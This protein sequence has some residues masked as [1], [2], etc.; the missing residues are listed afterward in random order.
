MNADHTLY[1]RNALVTAIKK[2]FNINHFPVESDFK[3]WLKAIKLHCF[4]TE[5]A[6]PVAIIVSS[7]LNQLVCLP[8]SDTLSD[9]NI[10]LFCEFLRKANYPLVIYWPKKIIAQNNF[11][12]VRIILHRTNKG[13]YSNVHSLERGN[14]A[15]NALASSIIRKLENKLPEYHFIES[16]NE[17]PTVSLAQG[18]TLEWTALQLAYDV[19]SHTESYHFSSARWLVEYQKK[20]KTLSLFRDFLDPISSINPHFFYLEHGLNI[21]Q[22]PALNKY[23]RLP[24]PS[25][26]FNISSRTLL[27]TGVV[28]WM[29]SQ[30]DVRLKYLPI[31]YGFHIIRKKIDARFSNP[32]YKL[33]LNSLCEIL[34]HTTITSLDIYSIASTASVL[35]EIVITRYIVM[36]CE[37]ILKEIIQLCVKIPGIILLNLTLQNLWIENND[38]ANQTGLSSLFLLCIQFIFFVLDNY[39]PKLSRW[40]INQVIEE[41][42]LLQLNHQAIQGNNKLHIVSSV[43]DRSVNQALYPTQSTLLEATSGNSTAKCALTITP[44]KSDLCRHYALSCKKQLGSV[45]ATSHSLSIVPLTETYSSEICLNTENSMKHTSA[46]LV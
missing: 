21:L 24:T 27:R 7:P 18:D 39:F 32:A 10:N 1:S 16:T 29:C 40:S 9:K 2:S 41:T 38:E 12:S 8:P 42:L 6:E 43:S 15:L 45:E 46:N 3:I 26:S 37:S 30:Q 33:L 11:F 35:H 36:I 4:L 17:N 5:S 13:I 22:M 44:A 19:I 28:L 31:L 34:I 14:S 25:P 23:S 20:E